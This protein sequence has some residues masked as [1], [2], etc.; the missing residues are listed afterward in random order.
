MDR[1]L[2]LFVV[3][4]GEEMGTQMGRHVVGGVGGARALASQVSFSLSFFLSLFLSFF[5][6][7]FLSL[8]GCAGGPGQVGAG[9]HQFGGFSCQ[10]ACVCACR[11]AAARHDAQRRRQPACA[12]CPV[13]RHSRVRAPR[14]E[15]ERTLT[16]GGA[17]PWRTRDSR[18]HGVPHSPVPWW[19]AI[20]VFPPTPFDTQPFT[21]PSPTLVMKFSCAQVKDRPEGW[22]GMQLRPVAATARPCSCACSTACHAPLPSSVL[23]H[24]PPSAPPLSSFA[25]GGVAADVPLRRGR[26]LDPSGGGMFPHVQALMQLLLLV[27]LTMLSLVPVDV[28]VCRC[29]AALVVAAVSV[30]CCH[31]APLQPCAVARQPRLPFLVRRTTSPTARPVAVARPLR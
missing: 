24:F 16:S 9:T 5:L 18:R 23:P 28:V 31:E 6:S 11:R 13:V 2:T 29:C 1:E 8:R 3:G 26:I 20:V 7:F 4:R 15:R 22:F 12:V 19:V 14:G 17:S 10:G 27:V 30:S 25:G 21:V